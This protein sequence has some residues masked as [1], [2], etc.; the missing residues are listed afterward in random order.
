MNTTDSRPADDSSISDKQFREALRHFAQT[1]ESPAA[2]H[3]SSRQE[4]VNT[5]DESA[6]QE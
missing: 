5:L 2:L 3:E 4:F 1:D 6:H